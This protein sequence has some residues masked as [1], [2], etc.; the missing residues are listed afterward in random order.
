MEEN[1]IAALINRI[2]DAVPPREAAF[3]TVMR[4][5]GLTPITIKRSRILGVG[6]CWMKNH[7]IH[8]NQHLFKDSPFFID[9]SH[10]RTKKI[11]CNP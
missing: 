1:E 9:T 2:T 8:E 6:A 5:S 11:S 3:F 7:W 10:Q 4:Q